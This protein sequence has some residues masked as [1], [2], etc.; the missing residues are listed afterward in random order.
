MNAPMT[1]PEGM[2]TMPGIGLLLGLP[3]GP[4]EAF[5]R[6]TERQRVRQLRATIV[7][8]LVFYNLYNL[9]NFILMQ[10]LGWLPTILRLAVTAAG[11]VLIGAVPHLGARLRETLVAIAMTGA[12]LVPLFLFWL[13]RSSLGPY[14]FSDFFLTVVY[15]SVLLVLRFPA[16]L[17]YTALC[18][19]LALAA[20][21]TQ[22]ILTHELC[23]ALT[24]QTLTALIFLLVSNWLVQRM[25]R[26]SYV[27]VWLRTREA[28]ELETARRA[29]A[30]LS[31]TDALTGLANRRRFDEALAEAHARARTAGIPYALLMID[32]DHFKR[33]ND[34]YGHP[35]GDGC[36]R[37]VAGILAAELSGRDALIARYGG[38][39]FAVVLRGGG[40]D[41]GARLA[42]QLVEA[43]EAHAI[44]HGQRPDT[45][46]FVTVSVGVAAYEV[47]SALPTAVM[48]A[49]DAAL[50]EA[51]R[52]GRNR[53]ALFGADE[54]EAL[55][56]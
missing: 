4:R 56:A 55:T 19:P 42:A 14:S 6:D 43:V 21:W 39:E 41:G 8:G 30:D 38:E 1:A 46:C 27:E 54:P 36:L 44:A 51:K 2:P 28:R 37:S 18:L 23:W 50:Y 3:P 52:R 16:A 45:G 31:A 12:S 24:L 17:L 33:F 48:R 22:P 20:I 7:L 53:H 32:V 40:M 29:F 47:T 5:E 13:T 35:A 25:H 15:A 49:A 26:E 11:G 10:E 9:S 34:A